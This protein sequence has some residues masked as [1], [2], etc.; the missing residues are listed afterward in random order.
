M[1]N[2]ILEYYQGI[3]DG[4]IVTSKWVTM[5]Y[6]IIVEGLESKR[7]IFD[8]KKANRAIRFIETRCHHSE[9]ALAPKKLKLEL[10]QKAIVSAI[11]GIIGEDGFRQF[12]EV[13]IVVGRKN[14][15]T[16]FASAIME[17]MIYLAAVDFRRRGSLS[18]RGSL[19]V[20]CIRYSGHQDT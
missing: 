8:Q 4:S 7:W 1:N 5:I 2:Y 11:F 13:L 6:D 15:K 19:Q 20:C 14:G 16:L 9:G 3:K 18:D 10:W 12:R 17:Y